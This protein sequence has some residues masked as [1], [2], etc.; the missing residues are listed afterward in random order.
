MTPK[1]KEIDMNAKDFLASKGITQQMIA[2]KLGCTRSNVSIWFSGKYA[3]SVDNVTRLTDALNELG[4]N[5]TYEE[6][7]KALWQSRQERK[8]A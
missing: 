3:P 8:G 7:F 1:E 6:V 2:D 4:A 5:V